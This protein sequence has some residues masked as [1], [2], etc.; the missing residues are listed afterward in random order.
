MINNINQT[1]PT[2]ADAIRRVQL[3]RQR[4]RMRQNTRGLTG[5]QITNV[6][7]DE[8]SIIDN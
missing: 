7:F 8:E 1:N 5:E 6:I 3:Q 4:E 2:A